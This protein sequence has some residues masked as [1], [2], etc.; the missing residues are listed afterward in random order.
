MLHGYTSFLSASTTASAGLIGLLFVA[1]SVVNLDEFQHETHERRTVLAGSAFL[2]LIDI[3]F[4]TLVSSL[5][6]AAL[7][8]AVNLVMAVV[9]LLATSRLMPRAARAGNFVR[10]FP[11]RNLN[12]AFAAVSAGGYITQLVLALA[13]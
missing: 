2:A 13:L 10:G 5:G 12:L 9:G 1:L 3:F 4:V 11:K 7:F 6:G 8:G